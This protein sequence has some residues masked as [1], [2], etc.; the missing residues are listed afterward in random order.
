MKMFWPKII[1]N[2]ELHRRA[3]MQLATSMIRARRWEWIGHVLRK[4]PSD[5]SRIALS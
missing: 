4:E 1:D 5:D 2:V 3:G